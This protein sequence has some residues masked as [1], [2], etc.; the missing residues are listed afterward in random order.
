MPGAHGDA[1]R[2]A[3]RQAESASDEPERQPVQ[4]A[5]ATTQC[6]AVDVAV[7]AS[8]ERAECCADPVAV[9]EPDRVAVGVALEQRAERVAEHRADR[10]AVAVADTGS[11]HGAES[12]AHGG[13]DTGADPSPKSRADAVP[14]ES[15]DP[16]ANVAAVGVSDT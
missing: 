13:A 6:F 12:I 14:L 3:F 1:E 15:P 8:V 7:Q 10:E 4:H 11:D 2:G 16:G 5:L 9:D